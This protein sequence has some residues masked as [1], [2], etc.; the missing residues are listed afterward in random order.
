MAYQIVYQPA[1]QLGADRFFSKLRRNGFIFYTSIVVISTLYVCFVLKPPKPR[2]R[3]DL[4]TRAKSEDTSDS[5]F[6][7]IQLEDL[8]HPVDR[9]S[10]RELYQFLADCKVYP[11]VDEPLLQ[12]RATAKRYYQGV[13]KRG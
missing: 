10:K 5:S 12:V 7:N 9:W 11:G 4:N 8:Q 6:E 13:E 2:P 3:P 1:P